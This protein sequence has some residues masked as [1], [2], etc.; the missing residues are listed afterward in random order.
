MLGNLLNQ[1]KEKLNGSNDS[2]DAISFYKKGLKWTEM[3]R[4][5]EALQEFKQS[6]AINPKQALTF[7][8]LGSAYFNL[9]RFSEA[10]KAYQKFLDLDADLDLDSHLHFDSELDLENLKADVYNNLGVIYETEG[11]FIKAIGAYRS[12][13][14]IRRNDPDALNNL[15][16]IYFKMGV[17]P[18]AIKAHEQVLS[19]KPEDTRAHFCLGLVYLDLKDR[20]LVTRQCRI[21]EDLDKIMASDLTDKLHG[22]GI[23]SRH[24]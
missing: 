22:V 8:R 1:V 20:Q 9:S 10:K 18:E 7:F 3:G 17:Y 14:R 4:F 2:G 12:A 13:I 11:D 15:G 19:F 16:E 23:N 21:L 5:K 6:A 24:R